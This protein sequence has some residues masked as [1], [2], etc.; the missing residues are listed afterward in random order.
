MIT[1]NQFRKLAL[2]QAGATEGSHMGHAD[3]RAQGRI[4]ATLTGDE[5]KGMV[6]LTPD[7]QALF[8]K[9][10]PEL[11]VPVHGAW[12]RGGA[13]YV[14]LENATAEIVFDALT[15]A[16]DNLDQPVRKSKKRSK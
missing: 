6:K 1:A 16:R 15:C 13:T 12:G 9:T 5:T 10:D 7:Q 4:F 14:I 3:F 11:F 2:R 8:V